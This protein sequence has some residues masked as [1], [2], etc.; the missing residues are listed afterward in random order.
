MNRHQRLL[1]KALKTR[2]LSPTEVKTRED[3]YLCSIAFGLYRHAD[4]TRDLKA[5]PD[6]TYVLDE[7]ERLAEAVLIAIDERLVEMDDED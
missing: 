1:D 3:K 4:Q 6:A 5:Q 7:Q 2:G